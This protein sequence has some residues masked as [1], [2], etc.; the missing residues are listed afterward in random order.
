VS[1]AS[2]LAVDRYELGPIGTNCYVVRSSRGAAEAVV[3][4]P[5]GDAAQLRLE[6]ARMGATVTA[7]LITHGH[8]DHLLAVADLAGGT[9]APVYMA[10]DER[11]L[12]ENLPDLVPQG[13][14]ARGYTADTFLHGG[15]TLE[16]AGI[17]FETLSVPGHSPAHLAYHADGCLFSGDVLFA[18]SVGRTDLPGGD[19]PTLL[20][21]IRGLVDKLPE[22]TTVYPGH[23][24][25]TSLGAEKRTNPFLAEL[26]RP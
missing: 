13:V 19:W 18:G 25:V 7:I 14:V 24:G 3:I 22:E 12:L 8:W 15:E 11:A 21:S 6:V 2:T 16:L 23:M 5:S 17:E 1:T 20:D 9:D 4:D 10:E 26:A